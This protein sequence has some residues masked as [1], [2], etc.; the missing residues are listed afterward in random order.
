MRMAT[1]ATSCGRRAR[2]QLTP[3]MYHTTPLTEFCRPPDG[4]HATI[5]VRETTHAFAFPH[6]EPK[7]PLV[8]RC[9]TP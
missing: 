1:V 6:E 5:L 4:Q 3:R 7:Q 2:T 9:E 8:Q